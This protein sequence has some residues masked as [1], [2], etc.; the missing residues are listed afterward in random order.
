MTSP[1]E[2]IYEFF[3]DCKRMGEIEGMFLST[4]EEI[5][6]IIGKTIHFGEI[7]GKHSEIDVDMEEGHFKVVTDDQDFIDKAK[8]IFEIDDGGTISGYNP[9]DY[10]EDEE[11]EEDD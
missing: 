9:F 5:K 10:I 7:L 8:K 1:K 3:V 4:E 2:K 6:S 11:D